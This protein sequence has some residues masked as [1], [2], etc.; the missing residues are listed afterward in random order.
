M[1]RLVKE[2]LRASDRVKQAISQRWS[3]WM[4]LSDVLSLLTGT[5]V[6]LMILWPMSSQ[7]MTSNVPAHAQSMLNEKL[8]YAA[9]AMTCC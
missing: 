9:Q 7:E 8:G 3:N 6:V 4:E 1:A 2:S 5:T